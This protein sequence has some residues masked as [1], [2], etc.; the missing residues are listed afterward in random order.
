MLRGEKVT[1]RAVARE[2]LPRLWAFNN[3][4][5]VELAGGGDPP[6][7]QSLARLEAEFDRAAAQGGRDGAS[8][9]I[10][11]DG[12][13][14]GSCGL[15]NF[16]ETAHTC[17]LGIGIGDRAYWGRGY[18]RDAVRLLLDYAF[19]LRNFYKVWLQVNAANAR[20][21]GAY[22][23]CGFV[24]EGRLRRH[25]WCDGRYDDLLYMGVL[26]DEWRGRDDHRGGAEG[27]ESEGEKRY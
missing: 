11:A 3:D 23:A 25:V 21:I 20:A 18:G 1:L 19:R 13:V 15:F 16:N 26:A 17:E 8:F 6:M 14:I 9:A 5:A 27:A 24:E 22:R 4:L 7:P 10:E 12:Q 2:D